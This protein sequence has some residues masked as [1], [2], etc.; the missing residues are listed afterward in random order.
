M[1]RIFH[2][3]ERKFFA[4]PDQTFNTDFVLRTVLMLLVIWLLGSGIYY[5]SA[6]VTV[7]CFS[8]TVLGE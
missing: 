2:P 6:Y 4:T 8:L 5:I 3:N 1:A 7:S